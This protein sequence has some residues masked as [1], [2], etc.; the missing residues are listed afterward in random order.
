M[1]IKILDSDSKK[2]CDIVLLSF[3]R[4][5]GYENIT[6][7]FLQNNWEG[8]VSLEG[9]PV[10]PS[11][12][13]KVNDS[14]VVDEELLKKRIEESVVEGEIVGEI[15]SLNIVFE[16]ADYLVLD[17]PAGTVM[18]P[19]VKRKDGTLVNY[20]VG[21]LESKGEYDRMVKRGGIVHRLDRGVSGLVLFAK[22]YESQ[23]FLQQKFENREVV[24]VYVADVLYKSVSDE[25]REMMEKSDIELEKA[26]G[27]LEANSFECDDTWIKVEGYIHRSEMNRMK[28]KLSSVGRG[29][30]YKHSLTYIKPLNSHQIIVKIETGRMHQIRASLEFLGM[31]IVGDTLYESL[32]GSVLP[33]EISLRS[34]LLSFEDMDGKRRVFR[35]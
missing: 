27:E 34:V 20:V 1:E 32:G 24:K 14:L 4:E 5:N 6:R 29:R 17:K 22:R 25:L 13:V 11:L 15:S 30:G 23:K 35:L 31:S 16:N 2:R 12:K 33:D 9:M 10:K 28:M 3:L 19:G 26:L 8:L 18:H 21:Y 7:S